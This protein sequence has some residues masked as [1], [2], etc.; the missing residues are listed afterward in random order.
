MTR[1]SLYK[2]ICG[3]Y[4]IF[5]IVFCWDIYAQQPRYSADGDTLYI[6]DMIII[7][8]ANNICQEDQQAVAGTA[9]DSFSW[10]AWG[11]EM[12]LTHLVDSSIY[13]NSN[14]YFCVKEDTIFMTF[15]T[16]H[17]SISDLVLMSSFDDGDTW[18]DIINIS[19]SGWLST[20]CYFIHY[21]N[22]SLVVQGGGG[23]EAGRY[24]IY[25]KVSYDLGYSW[26]NFIRFWQYPQPALWSY[27]GIAKGDTIFISCLWSTNRNWE[28][29]DSVYTSL[30]TD[31][32]ETWSPMTAAFWQPIG[33][34][35]IFKF[36]SAGSMVHMVYQKNI[37]HL[38]EIF[39]RHSY[40]L[41]HSW[42]EEIPISDMGIE[43][44]Q[45]PYLSSDDEGNLFI[46]WYDFKYGS[47]GG[48]WAG[49]L[50]FRKSSD[51]GETWGPETRLTSESSAT[52]SRSFIDGD[53]IGVV[54]VDHRITFFQA[55]IYYIESFDGGITWS[56]E[57]RLTDAPNLSGSPEIQKY[58]EVVYL[59]WHD[60]RHG[61]LFSYEEYFRKGSIETGIEDNHAQPVNFSVSAY[62]NPFN[63]STVISIETHEGGDAEIEIFNVTGQKVVSLMLKGKEGKVIW[64]ATDATGNKVSSGIYFARCKTLLPDRGPYVSKTIK[65]IYLR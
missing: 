9:L 35:N 52:I 26:N 38:S 4:L 27:P 41:G 7:K 56:E 59:F 16:L 23:E 15:A 43:H 55:E 65:L 12:R 53:H 33:D 60:A 14:Q 19:N 13:I 62:P 11:E 20:T 6:N 57:H 40:D 29:V 36:S 28:S 25:S 17:N 3:M 45:I 47:S 42:E 31:L 30:S 51:N 50:L 63:S 54:W 34:Y 10:T 44:S 58:N 24:N 2:A 61:D 22:G 37:S 32:G 1:R 64:D 8:A 21:N 48:G 39:Y 46:T 18:S 5:L 49:D